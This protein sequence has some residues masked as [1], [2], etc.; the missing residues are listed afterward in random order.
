MHIRLVNVYLLNVPSVP[1][2]YFNKI[3]QTSDLGKWHA[4]SLE[5]LFGA[6]FLASIFAN[7]QQPGFYLL[8]LTI[9]FKGIKNF[10]QYRS[11]LLSS[12]NKK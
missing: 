6:I 5:I 3:K 8:T 7:K 2:P 11:D 4:L 1:S 9:K 12:Q 10:F